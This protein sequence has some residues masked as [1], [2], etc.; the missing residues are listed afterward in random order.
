MSNQSPDTASN[1]LYSYTDIDALPDRTRTV[2]ITIANQTG[3]GTE[4]TSHDDSMGPGEDELVVA[5][6]TS[7]R[8]ELGLSGSE[9]NYELRKLEGGNESHCVDVPLIT[10]MQRGT[11][12]RGR[13]KPKTIELTNAGKQAI[14]DD[15]VEREHLHT[16]PAWF[17]AEKGVELQLESIADRI[18]THEQVLDELASHLGFTSVSELADPIES[19]DSLTRQ[20]VVADPDSAPLFV[21]SKEYSLIE[22]L[23]RFYTGQKALKRSVEDL[24]GDPSEHIDQ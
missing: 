17:P 24:G 22:L 11:D 12:D 23:G 20:A 1:R 18:D 5:T 6:T 15:V 8:T 21:K 4:A 14:T 7:I 10:T 3:V 19:G 16:G 9:V 2:L 13:Q